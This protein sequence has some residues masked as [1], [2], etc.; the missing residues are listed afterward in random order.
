MYLCIYVVFFFSFIGI[1]KIYYQYFTINETSSV[2]T[3]QWISPLSEQKYLSKNDF[4]PILFIK[5]HQQQYDHHLHIKHNYHHHKYIIHTVI[6]TIKMQSNTILKLGII[7]ANTMTTM[8]VQDTVYNTTS[9]VERRTRKSRRS[10]G[11][12]NNNNGSS[13]RSSSRRMHTMIRE[14]IDISLCL[15]T[16]GVH[17]IIFIYRNKNDIFN[18]FDDGGDNGAEDLLL[19]SDVKYLES[20][21]YGY[22]DLLLIHDN[23]IKNITEANCELDVYHNHRLSSSETG[24][25]EAHADVE[26]TDEK[27]TA[28]MRMLPVVVL[29]D[30]ERDKMGVINISSRN[31]TSTVSTQIISFEN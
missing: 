26:S 21:L 3:K 28:T 24:A 2:T 6:M 15:R 27:I 10:S 11:S 1:R 20:Q 19:L 22:I 12:G 4:I 18:D 31:M 23:N 16:A 8:I 17:F 7:I 30:S 25:H 13:R 29:S 9:Y 14:I 5:Q